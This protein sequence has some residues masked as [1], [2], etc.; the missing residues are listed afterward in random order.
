MC[1][2]VMIW[3]FEIDGP[4]SWFSWGYRSF[5]ATLKE[6]MHQYCTLEFD[7]DKLGE[8]EQQQ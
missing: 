4:Q 5:E 3:A 7:I 8:E 6:S 1:G 2:K